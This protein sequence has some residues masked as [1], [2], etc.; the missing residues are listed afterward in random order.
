MRDETRVAQRAVLE[1]PAGDAN[2]TR[3]GDITIQT[4]TMCITTKTAAVCAWGKE[5]VRLLEVCHVVYLGAS[6]SARPRVE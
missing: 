4:R 2:W 5:T 3:G 6:A 1:R